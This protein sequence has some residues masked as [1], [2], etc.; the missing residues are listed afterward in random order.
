[1]PR[2]GRVSPA[3]S[4]RGEGR[5]SHPARSAAALDDGDAARCGQTAQAERDR[6]ADRRGDLGDKGFA[7]EMDLQFSLS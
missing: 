4:G 6:G 3:R 2:P 7:G 1:M 5:G